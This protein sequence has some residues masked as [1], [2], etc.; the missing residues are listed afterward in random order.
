MVG[1]LLLENSDGV[2]GLVTIC[3]KGTRK[4]GFA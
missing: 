1:G 3:D 2:R 4:Y